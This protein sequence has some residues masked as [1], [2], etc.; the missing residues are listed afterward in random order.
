MNEIDIKY[1]QN[2]EKFEAYCGLCEINLYKI[3]CQ[4]HFHYVEKE[5]DVILN[6]NDKFT[7]KEKIKKNKISDN[8]LSSIKNIVEDKLYVYDYRF[9]HFVRK[10]LGNDKVNYKLFN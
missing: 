10:M 1:T 7:F 6:E 2:N 3:R 4:E 8:L 9:L 5:T